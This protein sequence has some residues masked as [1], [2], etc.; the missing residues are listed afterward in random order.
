MGPHAQVYKCIPIARLPSFICAVSCSELRVVILNFET[1]HPPEAQLLTL[2][3]I[4]LPL[5]I[6][7]VDV[8]V[9]LAVQC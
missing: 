7:S 8:P 6:C 1:P 3:C 4:N 5:S 9:P 2:Q